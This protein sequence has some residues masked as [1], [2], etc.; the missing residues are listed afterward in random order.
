MRISRILAALVATV[1]LTAASTGT[2]V[3]ADERSGRVLAADT[4]DPVAGLEV[5]V[6]ELDTSSGTAEPG[7]VAGSGLT[8]GDGRFSFE[9]TADPTV[10]EFF[11]FVDGGTDYQG[12]WY[13]GTGVL[14]ATPADAGTIGRS[15]DIGDITVIPISVSGRT[16]D[17]D[18]GRAV[19]FVLVIAY[20]ED[21]STVV[22]WAVSDRAGNFRITGVDEE[23][24][25]RFAGV[26]TRH[27]SG[28]LG[29]GGD[30][31]PTIGES[32]TTSPGDKGDI[33]LDRL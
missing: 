1:A 31:V 4:G 5:T 9:I 19:P 20:E 11:L 32:C 28:W 16:V 15:G 18:T 21:Y 25:L 24:A 29:C 33:R 14:A 8:G 30:V 10:E 26:L 3:A 13:N 7:A 12:G 6:Y 22:G 27:E 23:F 17:A 2:A